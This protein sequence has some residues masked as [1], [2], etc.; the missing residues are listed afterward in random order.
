MPKFPVMCVCW[1]YRDSIASMC[2]DVVDGSSSSGGGVCTHAKIPRNQ[3]PQ[4]GAIPTIRFL[5]KAGPNFHTPV[6]FTNFVKC[7][8]ALSDSAHSLSNIFGNFGT[9]SPQVMHTYRLSHTNLHLC[10]RTSALRYNSTINE[11]NTN[12]YPCR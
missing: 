3:A 7:V 6:F 10:S 12:E 11:A 8:R 4:N 5:R 9:F 2:D 1:R